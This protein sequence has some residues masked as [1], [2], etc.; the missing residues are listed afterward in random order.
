M[1]NSSECTSIHM[2]IMK[3]VMFNARYYMYLYIHICKLLFYVHVECRGIE[4][5]LW[6]DL[7]GKPVYYYSRPYTHIFL[8]FDQDCWLILVWDRS[9]SHEIS[10]PRVLINGV[11]D[12]VIIMIDH[13]IEFRINR[14]QRCL[15]LGVIIYSIQA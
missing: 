14:H 5:T 7:D 12:L 9:F 8:P 1:V 15:Q 6:N 3:M 4:P 10:P 13:T 11:I 2:V